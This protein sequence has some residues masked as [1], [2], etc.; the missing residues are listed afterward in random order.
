MFDKLSHLSKLKGCGGKRKDGNECFI[1]E[2]IFDGT[3]INKLKR[4]DEAG[5]YFTFILYKNGV[6]TLDA[7]RMLAKSLGI[8]P[9]RFSVAGQK[10]KNAV[11]FQLVSCRKDSLTKEDF[12]GVNSKL[13]RIRIVKIW[14][15]KNRIATG[16]L[17]GNKFQITL[18]DVEDIDRIYEILKDT[19]G[20]VP[21]YFGPQRFGSRF[22]NAEIGKRILL[23]DYE[24]AVN[25]LLASENESTE[26]GYYENRISEYIRANNDKERF[27]KA[28][29]LIPSKILKIIIEAYQSYLF[30]LELS[31]RIKNKLLD[32]I[33]NDKTCD[34]NK[35]GYV[36]VDV[37]GNKVT[38][39][40]IIGYDS[41][42]NEIALDILWKEGIEIGDF[43]VR[44]FPEVGC[45]GSWRPL[46]VN[47]KDLNISKDK[48][49]VLEFNLTKG[50]YATSALRELLDVKR[51]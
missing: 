48:D 25:G 23:K 29:K 9:E 44:D 21:N 26:L 40:Q 35:Y 30:N 3:P 14:E 12:I 19:N 47:V 13:R 6:T 43:K 51:I 36:D 46:L 10:D 15:T 1:V 20:F 38:C 49:Y 31:Y 28:V 24:G 42:P 16:F 8:K 32:P 11:T 22:S 18:Q 5:D 4:L 34:F 39:I 27:K 7:V 2:E 45:R 33:E 17:T 50:A 37:G 41:R